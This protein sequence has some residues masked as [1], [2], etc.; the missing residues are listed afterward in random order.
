VSV[1]ASSLA[2]ALALAF[3]H[4]PLAGI[5]PALA[6]ERNGPAF[7]LR[8]SWSSLDGSIAVKTRGPTLDACHGKIARH[9]ARARG[10]RGVAVTATGWTAPAR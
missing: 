7:R 3:A 6:A 2:G 10:S 5:A 9:L 8:A 4:G 1:D